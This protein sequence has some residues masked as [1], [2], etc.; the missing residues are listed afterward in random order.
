M[1]E[2]CQTCSGQGTLDIS[3]TWHELTVWC[4]ECNST[5]YEK[6]LNAYRKNY[7]IDYS[8]DVGIALKSV[9]IQ[10]DNKSC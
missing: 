10:K 6:A 3:Q 5:N 8:S 1:K 2:N 4:P 9:R 7:G